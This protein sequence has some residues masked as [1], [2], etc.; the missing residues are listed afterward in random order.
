M[1]NCLIKAEDC[2]AGTET[3][4]MEA[5]ACAKRHVLQGPGRSAVAVNHVGYV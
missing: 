4:G 3:K 5:D 2:R 1:V